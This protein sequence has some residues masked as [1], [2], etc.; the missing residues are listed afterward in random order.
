LLEIDSCNYEAHTKSNKVK[1]TGKIFWVLIVFMSTNCN[2]S[3]KLDVN[4]PTPLPDSIPLRF[5]PEI[6]STDSLDFNAEFSND[7]SHFYFCRG[8]NGK[9]SIYEI[10]LNSEG[11][12]TPLRASFSEDNYSQADPFISD[13]GTLY[14]ISNRPQNESDSLPDYNIWCVRPIG[15][16]KWSTPLMVEGINTDSTEY[17]VSLGK[18][19]SIYFASNRAGGYGGLDLYYSRFVNGQ[20]TMPENLGLQINTSADEH[21]PLIVGEEHIIFTAADRPDGLGEA[22]LYYSTRKNGQWERAK[23][24]GKKFNTKTYEYCPNF[25]P[26]FKYFFYSSEFDVKWIS[27]EQLPFKLR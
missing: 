17:Y 22:D 5:M 3:V 2:K 21:D 14:Y 8:K 25:S 15:N 27:A 24:L 10:Q 13:D 16:G 1:A 20:F 26:D 11:K 12:L 4:Y 6:V 18:N 7:G 9:W 23:N 19:G